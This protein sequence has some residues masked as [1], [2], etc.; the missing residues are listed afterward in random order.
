MESV[1]PGPGVE[2]GLRLRIMGKRAQA[3]VGLTGQRG[4]P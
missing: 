2:K 4:D 3:Q 1:S